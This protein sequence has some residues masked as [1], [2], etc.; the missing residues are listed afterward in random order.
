MKR[1]TW[2]PYH[3]ILMIQ[4]FPIIPIHLNQKYSNDNKNYFKT[5][6]SVL[7]P[8]IPQISTVKIVFQPHEIKIEQKHTTLKI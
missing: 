2:Q 4:R 7:K 5:I 8:N 3:Q 6:W 1:N